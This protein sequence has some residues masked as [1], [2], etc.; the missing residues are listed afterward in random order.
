MPSLEKAPY[1]SYPPQGRSDAR[2]HLTGPRTGD[3]HRWVSGY[4]PPVDAVLSRHRLTH[5]P[6]ALVQVALGNVCRSGAQW[7]LD[8]YH[9]GGDNRDV[10]VGH[11]RRLDLRAAPF[12]LGEPDH[13]LIDGAPEAGV[14]RGRSG[15]RDAAASASG[16][17]LSLA[18]S[19]KENR[20]TSMVSVTFRPS[21]SSVSHSLSSRT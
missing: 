6:N 12:H 5:L 3:H 18:H 8:T 4:V 17:T 11:W 9:P 15:T 16:G 19:S 20:S 13:T 7:L 2:V 10:E 21:A 14:A 1:S